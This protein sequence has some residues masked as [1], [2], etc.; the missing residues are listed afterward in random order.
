MYSKKSM[1]NLIS[2][3]LLVLL[4]NTFSYNLPATDSSSLSATASA[5]C[6]TS[7]H[8]TDISATNVRLL[9]TALCKTF[10]ISEN[11]TTFHKEDLCTEELLGITTH[12]ISLLRTTRTNR[13]S[14]TQQRLFLTLF[15]FHLEHADYFSGYFST[16]QI[17]NT[18][19]NCIAILNY[20]HQQDGKKR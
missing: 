15:A 5:N 20:I 18:T 12:E 10:V 16:P 9:Y 2:L 13:K 3:L 6:I 19:S 17:C 11:L 1:C 8:S 4:L 14:A 7:H